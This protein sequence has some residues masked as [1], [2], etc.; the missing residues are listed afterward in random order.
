MMKTLMKIEPQLSAL[1]RNIAST[2][3]IPSVTSPMR[4]PPS[5]RVI[6]LDTE[7]TGLS[8]KQGHRIVEIGCVELIDGVKTGNRLHR[9][10]NPE[11][12][13]DPRAR[14]IHGLSRSFLANHPTFAEI[15]GEF[16]AF[17]RGATLVIHNAPFDTGF[18]E[19][20]LRLCNQFALRSLV[21][22]IKDTVKLARQAFP[23]QKNSL[24]ALCERFGID[25]SSRAVH[26]ALVDAELLADAYVSLMRHLD[27]A[28][29][30]PAAN[31]PSYELRP[32]RNGSASL[33]ALPREYHP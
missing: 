9:Y 15:A 18:I 22:E 28:G 13:V 12:G 1:S 25:T 10:L 4:L 6:A 3:S 29:P 30:A 5:G 19:N 20:E 14:Q 16:T 31:M 32:R 24:D 26:G 7:T 11:R 21:P 17:I 33:E 27:L 23:G 8:W 2:E